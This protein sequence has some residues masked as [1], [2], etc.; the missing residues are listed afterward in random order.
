MA[1]SHLWHKQKALAVQKRHKRCLNRQYINNRNKKWY[2]SWDLYEK[3]EIFHML[4]VLQFYI[5]HI[6]TVLAIKHK[7]LEC[8]LCLQSISASRTIEFHN[9]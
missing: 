3:K 1:G 7:S 8:L 2:S 5:G 4:T 9:N 6:L